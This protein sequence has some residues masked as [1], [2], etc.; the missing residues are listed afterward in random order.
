MR[1]FIAF[2]AALLWLSPAAAQ[3]NRERTATNAPA[4]REVTAISYPY[5]VSGTAAFRPTGRIPHAEGKV[6]VERKRGA[7][8]LKVALDDMKPASLFGGDYNTYVL[9]AISPSGIAQNL[10][11]FTLEGDHSKLE[12][13]TALE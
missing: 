8:R 5:D 3:V 11:E 10:G 2:C 9:W 4:L 13:S 7:T 1:L 6:R 12:T